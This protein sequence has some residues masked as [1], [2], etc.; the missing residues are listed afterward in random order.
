MSLISKLK[1][2]I[3]SFGL[4]FYYD[5]KGGLDQL[6]SYA[7]YSGDKCVAYAFL[8]SN[9]TFTDGKESA[10]IGVF[11]SKITEFDFETIENDL[12]QQSCKE[13]A[14][15]FLQ[16]LQS[17]NIFTVGN[18]T[19]NYFFDEFSINITGVGISTTFTESVGLCTDYQPVV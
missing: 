1:S 13:I 18:V 2:E 3:E 17:G 5:S 10:T 12:I 8:L 7:D 9:T 16:R 14:F 11:F 6:L 15:N 19:L 4:A